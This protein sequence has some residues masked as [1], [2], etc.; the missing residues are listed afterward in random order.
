MI[1]KQEINTNTARFTYNTRPRRLIKKKHQQNNN[2]SQC[3]V[4]IDDTQRYVI[5]RNEKHKIMV[6]NDF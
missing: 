4:M 6:T 5:E 3:I 2:F 1:K